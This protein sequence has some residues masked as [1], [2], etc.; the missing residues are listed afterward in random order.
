MKGVRAAARYAKA[1]LQL[2]EQN[3]LTEKVVQDARM[4][5]GLISD[6]KELELLLSSPLV[7]ADKKMLVLNKLFEGK[8]ED[9]SLKLIQQTVKQNRENL[10]SV[11]FAE[12]IAQ[13]NKA[14]QIAKVDVT[15]AIPLEDSV[16][17]DIKAKLVQAYKL[18]KVE[19]V[20][21]VDES[22]LGGMILRIDDKQLDASIRR[23]LND[24]KKELV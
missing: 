15:T 12:M 19:L 4:I 20:E 2:A 6:S 5:H 13:Y 18:S 23:K 3:Q 8:V 24:I 16:R 1:L 17:E 7:K 21:K 14:N 9:L 22:L 10:L 11:I